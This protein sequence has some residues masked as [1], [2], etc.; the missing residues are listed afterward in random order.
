[1]TEE[2]LME[3]RTIRFRFAEP[4]DAE[5]I[6]SLRTDSEKGRYLSPTSHDLDAQRRWLMAYKERERQ[7]LEYYFVMETLDGSKPCGV[8]RIY[9]IEGDA[10]T[11]GSWITTH[12]APQKSA[13]ESACLIYRFAFEELGL[14]LCNTDVK[15]ENLRVLAFNDRFGATRTSIADGKQYFTYSREKWLK[16]RPKY[17][18]FLA[19]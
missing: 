11:W 3:G 2:H 18:R 17:A 12:D 5:F 10:F 19:A 9:D 16:D 1:M 4:D 14:S 7:G 8:A 15:L 13:F 6:L